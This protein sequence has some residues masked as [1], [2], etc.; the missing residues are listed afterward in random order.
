MQKILLDSVEF[1]ITRRCNLRCAHCYRGNQQEKDISFDVIDNLL[2]QVKYISKLYFSG[3]EPLLNLPAIRH[4]F[5]KIKDENIYLNRAYITTNGTIFSDEFIELMKAFQGYIHSWKPRD[6]DYLKSQA[7]V[8]QEWG[9]DSDTEKTFNKTAD[10]LKG[11]LLTVSTDRYHDNNWG[12]DFLEKCNEAFIGTGVMVNETMSGEITRNVGNGNHLPNAI[13]WK[14]DNTPHIVSYINPYEITECRWCPD[15]EFKDAV[16]SEQYGLPYIFCEMYVSVTGKLYTATLG[17]VDYK[18]E[19]TAPYISD[20]NYPCDV[21][22]DIKRYN[23][24]K[25]FCAEIIKPKIT[26]KQREASYIHS[27]VLRIGALQNQDLCDKFNIADDD[28][29]RII[30]LRDRLIKLVKSNPQMSMVDIV[31]RHNIDFSFLRRLFPKQFPQLHSEEKYFR[32]SHCKKNMIYDGKLIHCDE[33]SPSVYKCQ[34]CGHI[35]RRNPNT[36]LGTLL[37]DLPGFLAELKYL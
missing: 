30:D 18:S 19:D 36:A 1:E 15:M 21:F 28:R 8:F 35:T 5:N 34:Y 9:L 37:Q 2:D 23:L 29:K 11:V 13:D 26:D 24:G 16:R 7:T 25:P 3:G 10:G 27:L 22:A 14:K 32:C 6:T 17:N 12:K 20:L 31:K 33:V 4:V